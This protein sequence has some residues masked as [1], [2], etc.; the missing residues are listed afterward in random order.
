MQ[1]T[2]A[3][4]LLNASHARFVGRKG[5]CDVFTGALQAAELPFVVLTVHGPGG[6]GKTTLLQE[7]RYW[8]M[9]HE[10][11]TTYLDV[12]NVEPT[13]TAFLAVLAEVTE[14]ATPEALLQAWGATRERHVVFIDT[15]EAV[16]VLERWLFTTFLPQLSDQILVVMGSRQPLSAHWR[17][18][19]G[20]ETLCRTIRLRNFTRDESYAFLEATA[21]PED[22]YDAVLQNTHGHP[23]ALTLV[24]SV[25][26]Q[27]PGEAVAL[28]DDPDLIK[29]LLDRF[30][31]HV[32]SPAHRIALE[33]CALVRH[34]TEPL[35][36]VLLDSPHAHD[37]FAWLRDLSFI[38]ATPAGLIPNEMARDV[39]SVDLRWR[40]PA[41][42][43]E[44]HY[45]ARRFYKA[46]LKDASAAT[47]RSILVDY[48][49]LH[50][51]NAVVRP[52]FLRLQGRSQGHK[53]LVFER[54]QTAGDRAAL[55]ALVERHEGS[56]AV[57]FLHLWMDEQPHNTLLL[58]SAAGALA[59]F[60]LLVDLEAA[61][62]ESLAHDPATNAAW[63]YLE[64][65]QPLRSDERATHFRFW[66]AAEGYQ[67][68]SPV[69]TTV[70]IRALQHY[71]TTPRLAFTF[72]ACASAETWAPIFAY[73]DLARLPE[74]EYTIGEQTYGV[75]AHDWR[76]RPPTAWLD[77]LAKREMSMGATPP[78]PTLPALAVLDKEA[79]AAAIKTALRSVTKPYN[80]TSNPLLDARLIADRVPTD[81]DAAD[82]VEALLALLHSTAEQLSA[83]PSF[84]KGIRAL[85]KA[86][87][88]P[89]PTHEQAAERLNLPYSTFRRHL[90]KGEAAL[91]DRLWQLEINE[92]AVSV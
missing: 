56:E 20:W 40:N 55:S 72:F 51:H 77:V 63:T 38:E 76:A 12:R 54:L 84:A 1:A 21:I 32:P 24:K 75:F 67:N 52:F 64:Q 65:H 78:K 90:K 69:Q 53:P 28:G 87:L 33:G 39:L 60:M 74:A 89:A 49:Y 2:L 19:P 43:Q 79:F 47:Q 18:N 5:P 17:T 25:T 61:S 42:Y 30:V 44:L 27:Q 83:S 73:G 80:L 86:Y 62:P 92:D 22:A 8:C 91:I 48:V 59:G 85:D 23:F 71:L 46:A 13:P 36:R 35:L 58:R 88:H 66:M 41:W 15:F 70:F 31:M 6:I 3:H 11:A 50:R 34:L 7:F 9:H 57:P 81:A 10:I 16:Q 37:L 14:H 45:R 29:T 68:L 26:D 4:R 82:R